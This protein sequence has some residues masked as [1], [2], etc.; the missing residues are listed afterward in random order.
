MAWTVLYARDFV[1]EVQAMLAAVRIKL[2]AMA[3]VL[4]AIGPE[5]SRPKADT[6]KGSKYKNM[7]ELRFDADDGVW[8]AAFAFNPKQQ[9]ILL[10]ASD[11]KGADEDAFYRGLIK[12]ADERYSAHLTWLKLDDDRKKTEAKPSKT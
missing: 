5:L 10:V 4:A 12:V 2:A 8:R 9:A 7:K 1:P 3:R 11:K 6:L